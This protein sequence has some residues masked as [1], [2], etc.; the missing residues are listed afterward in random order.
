MM[1]HS[2]HIPT[3]TESGP[4]TRSAHTL[5]SA[6]CFPTPRVHEGSPQCSPHSPRGYGTLRRGRDFPMTSE[7][8]AARLQPG[9][10]VHALTSFSH[11]RWS[12]SFRSRNSHILYVSAERKSFHSRSHRIQPGAQP[13][14]LC[15]HP[16]SEVSVGSGMACPPGVPPGLPRGLWTG[17]GADRAPGRGQGPASSSPVSAISW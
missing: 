16:A 10:P 1:A 9:L 4:W 6:K 7:L 3:H 5:T 15:G 2:R 11:A 8:R 12:L 17:Q 13:R 14:A